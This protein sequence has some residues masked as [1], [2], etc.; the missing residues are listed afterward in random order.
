MPLSPGDKLGP[1]EILALVG[2]GGMGEV[3]RAHDDRLR[4]DVAIKVSNSQFTERFTREAHTIASLNHTNI[5]HLYDVGPNYLVMEFV[6]GADLKGPLDFDEALPIIQQLIDGIEAAHEKNIIHRDLKPANI[7]ITPE[8]VVKILDFGLAKAMEPP[9]ESDPENSPTLTMGATAVGTILGTA[10]YMAPEQAKG[11]TADKRSDIW[12]FGVVVY[13]ML[14]GQ[15]LFQGESVVEIL[16]GVLNK[17]PD[18]S[19]APPRVHKLFSWCLQKDRK[20]RLASIS[21]ARLILNEPTPSMS[22]DREGADKRSRLPWIVAAAFAVITAVSTWM[23]WPQQPP[24]LVPM[25]FTVAMPEGVQLPPVNPARPTVTVSPDGRYLAFTG[26][27]AT[28]PQSLWI[29]A[30]DSLSSQKLDKTQGADLPF[31]SPDSQSIGFFADGKLKRIPISGGTPQT[32]ADAPNPGGG[33]WFQPRDG[34]GFIIF[35]PIN[36]GPLHRVAASGGASTP[37]TELQNGEARHVFPQILPDGQRM[38]YFA[39]GPQTGIYVQSIG[40][41][42]SEKRLLLESLTR[43][44]YAPP[45]FI[46]YVRES[47]LVAQRLDPGSLEL[48]GEAVPIAE[49]VPSN[50]VLAPFAASGNGVVTYRSG[51]SANQR[52]VSYSRDGSK[53]IESGTDV[54][55]YNQ[56]VL[57][58]DD[59]RLLV[60]RRVGGGS[61]DLWLLDLAN[62]IFSRLT[63]GEADDADPVWA[64]DSRRVIFDSRGSKGKREIHEITVGVGTET[65]LYPSS[66]P[67][68]DWTRDGKML[69]THAN[70][71]GV[72]ILALSSE[73]AER[74]PQ[75]VFPTSF[76]VDEVHISPDNQWAAYESNESG[77]YEIYL[78]RFP[79]FTDRRQISTGGGVQPQWRPDGRELFYLSTDSKLMAVETRPG[80]T[81][82]SGMPRVLFQTAFPAVTNL[83][84]YA[85]SRDGQRFYGI[86]PQSN[87]A[88]EPIYVIV[89][90]PALVK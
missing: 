22:R 80:A 66:E 49:N 26:G 73:T 34:A 16:G 86:E 83:Q 56:L 79:A 19:P 39:N 21:D 28:D 50:N 11:K 65:T 7:K 10:A 61:L 41:N 84:H 58:P 85:P 24:P 8:G 77:Q 1:Y 33:T 40:G 5:A 52:I 35:T 53:R 48:Q 74:K 57:S 44:V 32:L 3:Y 2:K 45:G 68:D 69:V 54:G 15:R 72:S 70:A 90:W 37:I 38:L 42:R 17:D 51:S 82:Q 18:I 46:L 23:L 71:K 31:W 63:A 12:S 6:E 60:S 76:L 29:R 27:D 88:A 25:R 30:L 64:P 75:L 89:N 67:I 43:A 4:R 87:T 14:T 81:L 47:S 13:E 62:H 20:Q 78:A 59:T 55:N 9:Q 36:R